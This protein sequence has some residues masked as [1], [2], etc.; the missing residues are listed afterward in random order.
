VFAVGGRL[1]RPAQTARCIVLPARSIPPPIRPSKCAHREDFNRFIQAQGLNPKASSI[2]ANVREQ[3]YSQLTEAD[4]QACSYHQA[5]WHAIAAEA[6]R[7]VRTMG[8]Y[9][10]DWKVERVVEATSLSDTDRRWLLSLLQDN[11][12]RW[13]GHDF[14]DGQH[15]G[16]AL[17]SCGAPLIVRGTYGPAGFACSWR[18]GADA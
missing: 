1:K 18:M 16:C 5:E 6:V 10:R 15:R 13:S 7:I 12:I 8:E 4:Y 11:P 14:I 3:F 17:R 9:L 2:P